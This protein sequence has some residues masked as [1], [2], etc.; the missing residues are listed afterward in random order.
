M[1]KGKVA[2]DALE[3]LLSGVKRVDVGDMSRPVTGARLDALDAMIPKAAKA[4]DDWGWKGGK[5]GEAS[6]ADYLDVLREF[7]ELGDDEVGF[8]AQLLES[9][10]ASLRSAAEDPRLLD[11]VYRGF[12]RMEKADIPRKWTGKAM[13]AVL[14]SKMPVSPNSLSDLMRPMTNDQRETFLALLPEW[15]GSM[16]DLAAA[17]RSL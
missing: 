9:K 3:A 16:D 8:V 1:A 12:A 17:A 15:T 7:G 6:G 14:Q 2:L 10:H 5:P 13:N 11:R 4:G